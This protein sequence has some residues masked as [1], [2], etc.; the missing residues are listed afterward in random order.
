MMHLK[1]ITL[2]AGFAALAISQAAARPAA[3]VPVARN[4]EKPRNVIF[5]L[6]DDH[7]YDF[8]GFTGAVPWLQTPA[9]DRM[10]R[11]GA[12]MK[13][14]FVTTSLSSPSRAS[15]LTGL[16]THT[17]T[18]VDN[19][20]PKPDDLVF[21]PQY[22]QQNGYRTAFFG[23]WHMGNQDDMPQPGFDHWEGFRGQG[24]YYNTVLNINGERV[25]FDPELYSTDILTDH[26]IDF[27]R[28]NEEGP[29]FIYL[30]YKSVHSG[31]QP[32]P[33]RKG[34]Y[35]DEKAVYPPSFNVPEYGIPRLPGK[36][37]D[38]RPLAGRG[39]YGE[40]RLPDWVKNQR[41]SWHGVDYQ[42]HGALPYEEDF[43]NYCETVTSM[44]DAIGRLLDFLQAEGLGEST[45]VIYMG[46]NGFMA[47][48]TSC[49]TGPGVRLAPR[50]AGRARGWRDRRYAGNA[51]HRRDQRALRL[52]FGAKLSIRPRRW[53][54]CMASSR[55]TRRASSARAPCCGPC[56]TRRAACACSMAAWSMR[57]CCAWPGGSAARSSARQ[58]AGG[59]A[60]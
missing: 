38:G 28:D 44:D 26:A 8:M 15:I 37:A 34:M 12:C 16:F 2:P 56:R 11:E 54:P 25:K 55:P 1:R 3:P 52:G 42:Y 50:R 22:L 27:V 57:R 21:F 18:V 29:F 13:N 39:W 41:E 47:T 31:F 49:R 33:S 43:R 60:R 14:A 7:R 19:Q 23:K 4:G 36:D 5:I 45:L 40:S 46:D 17:H 20:A 48:S 51:A 32:S 10:A 59:L 30:S 24:T 35:K 58:R 9:L 6:S 53:P